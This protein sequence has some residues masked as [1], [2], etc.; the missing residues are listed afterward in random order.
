MTIEKNQISSDLIQKIEDLGINKQQLNDVLTLLNNTYHTDGEVVQ[1]KIEPAFSPILKALR[2][3]NPI[4]M[5]NFSD[6]FLINMMD[7]DMDE[8]VFHKVLEIV[9]DHYHPKQGFLDKLKSLRTP[10]NN[11]NNSIKNK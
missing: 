5:K 8:K 9:N 2:L 10:E 6:S 3:F 11:S 7:I 1:E 4:K